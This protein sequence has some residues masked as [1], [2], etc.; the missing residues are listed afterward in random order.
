MACAS[1]SSPSRRD[2]RTGTQ[3]GTDIET[4]EEHH[5]LAHLLSGLCSTSFLTTTQTCLGMVPPTSG[6]THLC[7]SP[8]KTISHRP[9]YRQCDLG[10]SLIEVP[11][12][13]VTLG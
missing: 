13:Q 3:A 2:V 7:Q 4:I 1:D 12:A 10:N 9:D 8:V 6:W 11:S 5:L